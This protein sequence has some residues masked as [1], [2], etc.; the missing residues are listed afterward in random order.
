MYGAL[1]FLVALAH[2]LTVGHP[3]RHVN[4]I[5]HLLV[6]QHIIGKPIDVTVHP[7]T[8]FPETARAIVGVQHFR[9]QFLVLSGG[10]LDDLAS[11]E[12]EEDLR[13]LAT[14]MVERLIEEDRAFDAVYDGGGEDL[15]SGQI[16]LA[17][18]VQSPVARDA[19]PN[20]RVL[21]RDDPD[22]FCGIE[23][24]DHLAL[25]L[26]LG[27]PVLVD[28]VPDEVLVA[29]STHARQLGVR[30]R[31]KLR[32]TPALRESFFSNGLLSH[33]VGRGRFRVDVARL[34]GVLVCA[35]VDKRVRL[36]HQRLLVTR[37]L[38][39]LARA[40]QGALG[41]IIYVE[42]DRIRAAIPE[43]LVE[44]D[45]EVARDLGRA[46][47]DVVA[48]FDIGRVIGDGFRVFPDA[49]IH[50]GEWQAVGKNGCGSN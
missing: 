5:A 13:N 9:Q 29:L 35:Q 26:A 17:V 23:D 45:D 42:A 14:L 49:W 2:A 28:R 21:T 10:V 27:V 46:D 20:I 47:D 38:E 50:G 39:L 8:E 18:V 37:R 41:P 43:D 24:L 16:L 34:G 36:V 4:G 12:F 30:G 31:G 22:L 19:H 11:L 15:P 32:E 7:N 3:D 25:E 40:K 1:V 6:E 48:L 33:G 44:C